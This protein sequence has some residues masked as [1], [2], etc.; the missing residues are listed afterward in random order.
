MEQKL[1]IIEEME[2]KSLDNADFAL[3]HASALNTLHASP[4]DRAWSRDGLY[5]PQKP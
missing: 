5:V 2:R 3:K 4:D 1:K